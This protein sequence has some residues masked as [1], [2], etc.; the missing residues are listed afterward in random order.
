MPELIGDTKVLASAAQTVAQFESG[1]FAGVSSRCLNP[2]FRSGGL[3][4]EDEE[5]ADLGDVLV[6]LRA[7]DA[8][9]ISVATNDVELAERI[10]KELG[11]VW[12]SPGAA[13]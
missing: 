11:G 4:T 12:A 2:R 13:R 6:E 9:Y 1:V 5:A 8:T 10:A 3:W 7:F